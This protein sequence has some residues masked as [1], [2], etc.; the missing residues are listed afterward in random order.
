M[1]TNDIFNGGTQPDPGAAAE[2]KPL[3][4]A[5]IEAEFSRPTQAQAAPVA[6]DIPPQLINPDNEPE[7]EPEPIATEAVEEVPGFGLD[8]PEREPVSPE[9]AHRT[10]ERIA[11]L[12]DT[13]F[14]FTASS[15]I[16]KT[17]KEYRADPRDLSDIADAWG[18]VAQEHNIS[19]G[20]EWTLVILYIMVYGPLLKEAFDDRRLRLIEE[21]QQ[22]QNLIQQQ[23]E[24]RIREVERILAQER[25]KKQ[26]EADGKP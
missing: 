15:F 1:D 16:A 18:E 26:E 13:G 4:L 17:N 6:G 21:E 19:I 7:P 8:E 12:I 2:T 24:E 9:R 10:G 22:R 11:R 23:Q 3:T 5:D 20:P 25:A 14:S